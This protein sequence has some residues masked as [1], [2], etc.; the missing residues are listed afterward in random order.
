MR[1]RRLNKNSY[2]KREDRKQSLCFHFLSC[3]F[4]ATSELLL[5]GRKI[6]CLSRQGT[7]KMFGIRLKI[8]ILKAIVWL[9][10]L[11]PP[12]K[13]GTAQTRLLLRDAKVPGLNLSMKMDAEHLLCPRILSLWKYSHSL[14]L[15]L[16]PCRPGLI[17]QALSRALPLF[18]KVTKKSSPCLRCHRD[19]GQRSALSWDYRAGRVY[20]GSQMPSFPPKTHAKHHVF[21][22]AITGLS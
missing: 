19:G 13:G 6:H 12:V 20:C 11:K 2:A 8:V 16:S 4:F 3:I 10:E 17:L 1:R 5:T 15:T 22:Q 18:L 7:V 9:W 14:F 21:K